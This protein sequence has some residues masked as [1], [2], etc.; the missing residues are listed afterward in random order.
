[1]EYISNILFMKKKY[2][3]SLALVLVISIF[4]YYNQHE[5]IETTTQTTLLETKTL[6]PLKSKKKTESERQMF[7]Q[8]RL[9]YELNMQKNPLTGT[10]PMEEKQQELENTLLIKQEARL[11][12]RTTPSTYTSRGPSNLGGRTRAFAVDL[13]DNTGNTML[14]GGVSS[15]LF[16][17]TNGGASW[18][19]V[20][21]NDEIHNVTALAQDPRAGHQNKWYYATGEW[22]GNTASLGSAYRGRGVWQ[23]TNSGL[24]WT[25]IPGTN[26]VFENY[27][28]DFDYVSALEVNP[29][30]GYL[31]IASNSI[32]KNIYIYDGN[33]L[34]PVFNG[35][36]AGWTDVVIAT[37]GRV[38]ASLEGSGV[39][40][41][42]TGN[43]GWTPISPNN[44]DWAPTGRIVLGEA[45]SNPNVIYAL[46]ANG[47][48]GGI[49]ADLW[50]YD[51]ST[52][53]WTDYSSKLP[54]EAGGDK[55]GNDPFAIQGGYDLVVS[56]KADDENFVV[57]GGTNV[58][59][60]EDIVND[61]TFTRIGG[62]IS[63]TSYAPYSFGGV[64][65]HSDIHVLE[66]DPFDAAILFSGTDGGVHKTLDITAAD[67][68]WASLNNNYVTYQFYHVALSQT[69]GSDMVMGG[70]QDNG[71]KYGG[72][73]FG[74]PDN[75]SMSSLPAGG[76]GVAISIG[77][78]NSDLQFYF[79]TQRGNMHAY[80]DMNFG[81]RYNIKPTGSPTG[82]DALFVTYFYLDPDN[83]DY[84]YYAGKP[85]LYKTA[86]ATT[87]VADTWDNAGTLS[88]N[89]NLRTFAT[90]RGA[91]DAASSYMLLGG[92][93]GGI[94]R[95]DDPVN[96]ASLNDAVNITPN[97]ATTNGGTVVSG[98]AIHPTNKDIVLAVYANYGINSIFLTTNATAA[99]PDWTLVEQNLS[100]HSIRSAAVTTVGDEIIYFVG[101]ARGLYSNSDPENDDW[102]I[103]G[104]DTIG[105]AV[106]SSLVYR[107]SDNKLLIGTHGNGMFETTVQGTLATNDFSKTTDVF[108]YPNPTQDVLNFRSTTL[109]FS[110]TVT[111][112]I[113]NLTGKRIL[114]GTLN[115]QKVDVRTL[116]AGV[117][118]VNLSVGNTTQTLKF[119]KN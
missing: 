77:N 74:L 88:T 78:L 106:V 115:N 11:S 105:L 18:T 76:D 6:E 99:N 75:T 10:I 9:L 8:E 36:G 5:A 101:T 25:Q 41:S 71:N 56:V 57:I 117:Y 29:T 48:S 86:T 72:S 35:G 1:L 90:T 67:I 103:E 46:Y 58:Y 60:I 63:N 84:L 87:V 112:E 93:S 4:W 116:N 54:D 85:T 24:T 65:H 91:Y 68:A 50:K 111:Y 12:R 118:F 44:S 42:P 70:A 7:A 26:S 33:N 51:Q 47:N 79:G 94:F 30:N 83:N 15:G 73:D 100:A 114:N 59:K 89:E 13:S 119:I 62:Y 55:L 81:Y 45:P 97:T 39:W 22:S 107:P 49:E 21:A 96:T 2:T 17:T 98:L 109:D 43:S 69:A 19:K 80:N 104:P 28:S 64:E 92:E 37:N 40:T 27:D 3:L 20:S 113:Y 61:A 102:D 32:A 66:F 52:T 23:S 53:T 110:G 95:F 82:N 14:S 16:R 38:F 31:F 108:L 34:T